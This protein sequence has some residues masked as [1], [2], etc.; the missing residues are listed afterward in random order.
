MKDTQRQRHRQREKQAPY[1]EH[2]AGLNPR[3][4]NKDLSGRQM[5]NHWATQVPRGLRFKLNGEY[6]SLVGPLCGIVIY[7]SNSLI[8]KFKP[9]T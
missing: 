1:G 7:S 2:D 8:P 5:L 9:L 3:T 4:L 6:A